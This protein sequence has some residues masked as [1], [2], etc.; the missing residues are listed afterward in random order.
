MASTKITPT[1][2]TRRYALKRIV[3]GM[4]QKTYIVIYI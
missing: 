1:V 4:V 3:M 2:T